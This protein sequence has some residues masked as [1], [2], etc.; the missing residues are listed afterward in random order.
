MRVDGRRVS[1]FWRVLRLPDLTWHTGQYVSASP[2]DGRPIIG[3]HPALAGLYIDTAYEG[4]GVMASPAGGRLLARLMQGAVDPER[5]P[6]RVFL[7]TPGNEAGR[8]VL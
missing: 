8:M 5:R 3:P 6:F 2:N 7:G 4:R 1:R